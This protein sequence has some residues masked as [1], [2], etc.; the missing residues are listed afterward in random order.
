M[1]QVESC[2]DLISQNELIYSILLPPSHLS[3]NFRRFYQ[4]F[5][6]N[7]DYIL[8]Y[9]YE[10]LPQFFS[11]TLC[12]SEAKRLKTKYE[13]LLNQSREMCRRFTGPHSVLQIFIEKIV[14]CVSFIS[15]N[16]KQFVANTLDLWD[17]QEV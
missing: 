16:L 9:D 6:G 3:P 17:K 8:K 1:A 13:N 5:E 14:A 11:Q 4:E 7:I 15:Q 2:S 10:I 12:K